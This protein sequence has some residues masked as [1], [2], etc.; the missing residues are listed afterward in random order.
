MKKLTFF[1]IAAMCVSSVSAAELSNISASDVQ[2]VK[3][4]LPAPQAGAPAKCGHVTGQITSDLYMMAQTSKSLLFTFAKTEEDF[5]KFTA[6]WT[7]ILSKFDMKVI[8]K[9]YDAKVGFGTLQYVS[10]NGSVIREFLADQMDYNAKDQAAINAL[11]H[12]LLEP[13][14]RAGMTPVAVLDV[15]ND[16]FRPTFKI[17]Y[18]TKPEENVSAER[19]L[20]QLKNGDDID[21]DLLT[22]AV[23][24]VKKDAAY[25]MVYIGREI[26]YKSK[27]ATSAEEISKK[28]DEYKKY[29]AENKKELIGVKMD[30]LPEPFVVADKTYTH[31]A[32]VYFFQ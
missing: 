25:S 26:G 3:M 6:M 10:A 7:P 5:G 20:R 18:Q 27:I 19:Q 8:A 21:F 32:N 14:E 11:K 4:E 28:V 23:Q 13:L 12:E 22:S 17:Y 15:N 2:A 24:L 16:I 31:Y 1:A 29:L 30:K 9:T